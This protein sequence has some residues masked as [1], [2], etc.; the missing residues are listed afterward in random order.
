MLTIVFAV[1]LVFVAWKMLVLGLKA[2]WGLA[3]ILATVVL[4]PLFIVGLAF[5]GL[6]Y[7]AVPFLIIAGVIALFGT[8]A[9][10]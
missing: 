9:R 3:K 6:F 1:A 2:A 7:L 5:V 10:A 4:L 8:I